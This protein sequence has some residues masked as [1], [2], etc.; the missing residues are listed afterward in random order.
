MHGNKLNDTRKTRLSFDFRVI[1][2]SMYSENSLTKNSVT[3]II[4]MKI[5]SYY[6]LT[7]N[8]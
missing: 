4:P 1:P 6:S 8:F 2:K 7:N 5:G 3:Q